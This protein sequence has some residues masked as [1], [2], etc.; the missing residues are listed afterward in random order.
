MKSPYSPL[1]ILTRR[2]HETLNTFHQLLG[3]VILTLL[4]LHVSFY[5]NFYVQKDLLA[6]KLQETYILCGLFGITS[7]TVLG[8]TAMA[9]VRKLSY[10]LFYMI[11]ITVAGAILCVMP[12]HVSHIRLYIYEAAAVY[13]SNVILRTWKSRKV[14]ATL[15]RVP[16]TNMIEINVRFSET[17]EDKELRRTTQAGQHAYVLLTESPSPQVIRSNPFS[18]SSVPSTDGRMRFIARILNGNTALIDQATSPT[19]ISNREIAIEGPYG[20]NHS[21]NLLQYDR[22]LFVAGG[23]GGTFIVPLYR[24]LLADL[25]PS[26]GS[27]RRQKVSFVW[28]AQKMADVAWAL[29]LDSKEKDAFAERLQIYLTR[30]SAED[31]PAPKSS[32][33][34][35][36]HGGHW[37]RSQ[38]DENEGGIELEERKN[39]LSSD[40]DSKGANGLSVQV[41]RPDLRTL[42]GT[43]LSS[44]SRE[45][46]AVFAC[47]PESL[48]RAVR[49]ELRKLGGKGKDIFYWEEKFAL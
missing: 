5:L 11:H 21:E 23:V 18:V 1:Q 35:N 3:R 22:V 17:A 12:F 45:R 15:K 41:G 9:P 43:T 44:S 36:E 31:Y 14:Y 29:P 33:S 4:Y 20:V 32:A 49:K 47:G 26:K 46:V 16:D 6:S 8:T 24:Q 34:N 27:Y 7:L 25:S 19:K 2:S 38:A 48:S 37:L 40:S 10:R 28:I 39:L 13:V 42:I 30:A